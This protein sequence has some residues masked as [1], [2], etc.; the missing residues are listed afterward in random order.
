MKP[1][2]VAA[3]LL[4]VFLGFGSAH[5]VLGYPVAGTLLA[6]T[7]A[8]GLLTALL[9]QDEVRI[10]GVVGMGVSRTVDITTVLLREVIFPSPPA[11]R[12]P[13]PEGAA[14]VMVL[15]LV[16]LSW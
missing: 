2:P 10:A 6:V 14:K 15:P 8:G 5:F 12:A 1:S 11:P 3:I 7:Q 9:F 16:N 4:S 13:R